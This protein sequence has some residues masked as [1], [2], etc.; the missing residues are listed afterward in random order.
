[1]A[2]KVGTIRGDISQ[3]SSTYGGRHH[4]V[5]TGSDGTKVTI[6]GSIINNRTGSGHEQTVNIGGREV[7]KI[8]NDIVNNPC[9][10]GYQKVVEFK[11][12]TKGKIY[13]DFVD[14]PC[15]GGKRQ[16]F[17]VDGKKYTIEND[18]VENS[19]TCGGGYQKVVK[20][21]EEYNNSYKPSLFAELLCWFFDLMGSLRERF[22][23]FDIACNIITIILLLPIIAMFGFAIIGLIYSLFIFLTVII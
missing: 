8:Y 20:E 21:C 7:G 2:K 13:N 12:G 17:E 14:N 6:K 19:S 22:K 10:G 23:V 4:Q 1:M 5:F 18:F 9:G 15:G 16:I 3:D 11:D